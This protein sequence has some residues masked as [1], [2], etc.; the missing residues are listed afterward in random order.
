VPP[1]VIEERHVLLPGDADHHPQAMRHRRVEQPARRHAVDTHRVDPVRRHLLEVARDHVRGEVPLTV[2]RRAERAVGDPL[3]EQLL[4]T[5]EEE[6]P[7]NHGPLEV[8]RSDR[9]ERFRSDGLDRFCPAHRNR[10]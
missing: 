3:H 5:N 1:D 7:A 2:A 10:L 8:K 4:V 9:L 6:L